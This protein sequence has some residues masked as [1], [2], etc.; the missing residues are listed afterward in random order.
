MAVKAKEVT[1]ATQNNN[2]N[3]E[4]YVI[5]TKSYTFSGYL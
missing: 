2:N 1:K 5:S 3:F 4:K